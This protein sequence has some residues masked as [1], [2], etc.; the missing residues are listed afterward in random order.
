MCPSKPRKASLACWAGE[1]VVVV[2]GLAVEED[3]DDLDDSFK[4]PCFFN[5]NEGGG[6]ARVFQA[7]ATAWCSQ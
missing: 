1:G 6:A 3:D 4:L 5:T 7:A 2:V